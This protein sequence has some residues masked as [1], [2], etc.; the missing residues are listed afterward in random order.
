M[1]VHKQPQPFLRGLVFQRL[2]RLAATPS[3]HLALASTP[4]W[5]QCSILCLGLRQNFVTVLSGPAP[6][7]CRGNRRG[8]ERPFLKLRAPSPLVPSCSL[9]C[10]NGTEPQDSPAFCRPP[11]ATAPLLVDNRHAYRRSTLKC[12]RPMRRRAANYVL[13]GQ[14]RRPDRADSDVRCK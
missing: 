6:P 3:D 8:S 14:A 10:P 9:P 1:L 4:F 5:I 11:P 2:P 12:P 13:F 7:F